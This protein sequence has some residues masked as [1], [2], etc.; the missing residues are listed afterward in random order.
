[1][2]QQTL[3]SQVI[4]EWSEAT[5]HT[6]RTVS[7]EG[8]VAKEFTGMRVAQMQLDKGDRDPKQR[9]TQGDR[10]VGVGPGIHQNPAHLAHGLV[11]T[12]NQGTLEIAL[13]TVQLHPCSHS[14]FLQRK[15]NLAEG[16]MSV[17][18]GLSLPQQVE[19]GAI[20][21]QQAHGLT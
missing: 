6:N 10:G 1:M 5:H 2:I 8:L 18:T 3:K 14:A 4:T 20:Q 21:E 13:K 16:L 7:Q 17:K 15:L 11:H 9:I 12:L 19:V